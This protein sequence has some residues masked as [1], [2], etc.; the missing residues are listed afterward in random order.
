MVCSLLGQRL[1][2]AGL[3][4]RV[5]LVHEVHV[6]RVVAQEVRVHVHD[7]LVLERGGALLGHRGGRGLG[8]ADR[9]QVAIDLVHRHERRR[10]A[11][12]GLEEAAAVEPLLLAEIVRHREQAVFHLALLLVLRIGIEFV[13]RHD[14]RRD[15]RVQL[16]V[17]GR[18]EFSQFFVAQHSTHR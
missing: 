18:N 11:G 5:A 3:A 8:L 16:Q 9:E 15:R 6:A 4:D 7:E 17:L 14:L 13:A 1:V 12:G 10:H 2:P